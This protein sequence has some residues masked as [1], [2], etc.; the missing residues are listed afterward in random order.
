MSKILVV[1]DEKEIGDLLEIYL[2]S[3]QHDVKVYRNPKE[4]V[5]LPLLDFDLAIIDIMMPEIDGFTLC[6]YIR[7]KGYTFPIIMLTAMDSDQDKIKGL[8]IGADDYMVKPFNPLEVVA[9]VNAQLRRSNIS[10]KQTEEKFYEY[11]GLTLNVESHEC[12]LYGNEIQ[13]T[14]TEF[15]ILEVLFSRSGK[16]VSSED[17]F[18]LVWKEKYFTSNN[19]TVIVHIQSIRKK[20]GDTKK[21][22]KFIKTVWGVGYKIE[23]E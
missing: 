12:F 10:N 6:K 13:L 15:S 2:Q 22:K 3:N 7:D 16:V 4:V 14:A 23:K 17:L 19:N 9:R 20:L 18:E 1:D 8:V 5:E 21:N 11:N